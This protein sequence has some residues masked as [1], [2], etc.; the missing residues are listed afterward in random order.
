[1]PSANTEDPGS[2]RA[3]SVWIWEALPGNEFEVIDVKQGHS[4][5]SE[6]ARDRCSHMRPRSKSCIFGTCDINWNVSVASRL[7]VRRCHMGRRM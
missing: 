7:I 2:K 1:M 5:V 3:C 4:Q 6:P